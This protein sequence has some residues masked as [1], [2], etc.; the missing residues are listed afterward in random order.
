MTQL[1]ITFFLGICAWSATGQQGI[2]FDR[3]ELGRAFDGIGGIS[4]GG[5]TSKLLVNY[6]KEQR[7]QILDFLFKPN[8]GASLNILK[9]EIGGDAQ[10]TD[11]TEASHMHN[12]WEENYERGYEWWLMLEAKKRNPNIKLV[13][14]PWAFPGWLKKDANNPYS[15]VNKTADYVVRW[16]SGAKAT[17][18]LTIDYLGIWNERYYEVSYIK[19]LRYTLDSK[20]FQNVKIVAA[21]EGWEIASDISKDTELAQIVHA[22]GCHYPGTGAWDFAISL[23]KPL[24]AAE[25]YS[26]FNDNVGAGCWARILNQNY[27][28]GYMTAFLIVY[29]LDRTIAWDL[30]A[31][32]YEDLPYT[33][34]GLMTAMQ[35]WSGHYVVEGPIWITAHTTQFVDLGWTYLNH[36]S[37]VGFLSKGGSYVSLVDPAG[38]HLTIIIEKMSHDHSECIR[39][40]LPWFNVEPEEVTLT[41]NG[42]FAHI[43]EMNVWYSKLG[44][45][46]EENTTVFFKKLDNIKFVNGQAKLSLQLDEVYTLTTLKKGQKGSYPDPPPPKPFPLPYKDDFESYSLYQE[47]FNLAQQ[48]GSF[49]IVKVGQNQ[50]VRQMVLTMPIYWCGADTS[51]KS[52]NY[53]GERSWKDLFIEVDYDFPEA[54][55]TLG[56][57]VAARLTKGGCE[58]DQS[59]GIFFFAFQDGTF[60]LANDLRREKVI[61]QGNVTLKSGWHKLSLLLQGENA[62][63]AIDGKGI[64]N[65]TVPNSPDY[66]FA[67]IGTDSFG[68][69]DF[70]NLYIASKEDGVPVMEKYFQKYQPR[71]LYFVKNFEIKN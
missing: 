55:A 64:F 7:D 23:K 19:A 33:R 29:N 45:G 25:D 46:N 11:G 14:L 17:Y 18:N 51:N 13:G 42:S 47:P 56:V 41:L 71:P 66:G 67:A 26:T 52:V 27:V 57:F 15:D 61:E 54:N 36:G 62:L 35:P 3:N 49:E 2:V 40:S 9:V 59:H 53:I 4:G 1:L 12:S 21:D 28:N 68:L 8:F 20:G 34:D 37:G 48:S 44:F 32:Y 43:T 6:P 16:V 10:T 31:S 58:A 60:I 69:A 39:P 70:D 22:L 65:V 5:A 24:W 38:E 63:G 30:I 50:V